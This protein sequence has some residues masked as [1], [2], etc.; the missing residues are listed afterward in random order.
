MRG[1]IKNL[2]VS[3]RSGNYGFIT[4]ENGDDRGDA[5]TFKPTKGGRGG[6]GLR[7]VDVR[8]DA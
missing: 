4:D 7:A 6:E 3:E 1:V 5:V 8:L 2:I